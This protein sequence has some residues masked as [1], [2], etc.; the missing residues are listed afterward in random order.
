MNLFTEEEYTELKTFITD[1]GLHLPDD[2]LTYVWSAYKTIAGVTEN[3]PCS[4]QSASGL[5]IKAIAVIRDYI[6]QQE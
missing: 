3:Q 1:L 4:C 6:N 5:W 2:K